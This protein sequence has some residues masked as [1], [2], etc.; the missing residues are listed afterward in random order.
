MPVSTAS[1][2]SNNLPFDLT[3][4]IGRRREIA[5]VKRL[6]S[7]SRLVTLTGVGGAGKT[8]LSVHV[9]GGVQRAFPDGVWF[10]ELA[11]LQDEALLTQTIASTLGIHDRTARWP[12]P[13]L[14]EY[15]R[16]KQLL[17]VLDNCEH[18]RD[19]SAVLAHA[20]LRAAPKLRI[21]ATSRQSLGLNGEHTFQVPTMS[22]PDEG[23]LPPL[24][25]L[26]QYEAIDLFVDRAV[27][28]QSTFALTDANFEAV[29]R[30][31]QRL[32]GLPLAVE[33]TAVRL[34]ALSVT[35]ILERL[36]DRYR[37]L[38]GGSTGALPRHQT[39]RAL[40]DWSYD[41]CSE[42]ERALW[43]RLSVFSG[44]FD[45]PA[46]EAICAGG[47]IRADGV[48]DVLAALVDKSIVVVDERAGRVRYRLL[49]TIRQYG[50]ERLREHGE[51]TPLRQIH[52]DYFGRMVDRAEAD[53][54]GPE[55]HWW[56]SWLI[57]EHNNLREA[58]EFCLTEPG[59]AETALHIASAL[60]FFWIATGLTSEG[61]R[62]LE[63]AL[64]LH[65]QACGPRTNALWVCAYLCILQEDIDAAKAMIEECG[66]HAARFDDA[67]AAAW[68]TQLSGMVAMSQ[69]NLGD[70]RTLLQDAL[71]RHRACDDQIGGVLDSCFYLV[72][73]TALLRDLHRAAQ[74]CEEALALCDTHGERWS[75]SYLL[76]DL[77]LVAWL[78]GDTQRAAA[79][80]L[81][82]LRL[83]REFNEQWAIAFCIEI[84]AWTANASLR[85]RRAARLLGA[86][87]TM[88]RRI[89]APLFGMRH[90]IGC[91]QQ[92]LDQVRNTL[93]G[94]TF[95]V[96]F[97]NGGQMATEEAVGYALE[98]REPKT[99]TRTAPDPGE[100]LTRREQEVAGLVAEGLSNKAIAEKLVIARRTA[101]AHVEHIFNKLGFS[102]R[103]Q[104][105]AWVIEHIGQQT[106][107]STPPSNVTSSP[108][109]G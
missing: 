81:A 32:D 85:H 84:L 20:L 39:L 25:A 90:F 52:R 24:A 17:L 82:G 80:G 68:V 103:S 44:G 45:L 13:A 86:A 4:F 5:E 79:S 109:L 6:L 40:V 105:A 49:E 30:I 16:D 59:E 34:R 63:R 60:R 78:L 56:L 38:N 33:L 36:E 21:L 28:V 48:L 43:A 96:E 75:K 108:G 104:I 55:Q 93:G 95:D 14:A 53:V 18:L 74:L 15:L 9:A 91:H 92:C 66:R 11:G 73:V 99:A 94:K 87:D 98:D 101:E 35:E 76:W 65:K 70:A 29:V 12:V 19:A 22:V 57:G 106:T 69:G 67:A 2:R 1:R 62:W 107:S 100:S 61:R 8:R 7:V 37:L 10:V 54:V 72:A 42:Q 77:G 50:R 88:W 23:R 46:A 64:Q 97:R 102:S 26:G 89:G 41:L 58:L 47:D 83:A 27:A 71:Q 51:E 31:C 3:R